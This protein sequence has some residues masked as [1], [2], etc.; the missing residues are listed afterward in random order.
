MTRIGITISSP[1]HLG[2]YKD[3]FDRI[4]E[5]GGEPIAIDPS[6]RPEEA[7]TQIDGLLLSGGADVTPA[8]YGEEPHPTVQAR[9]DLDA[10]EIPLARQALAQRLPVLGI[11]RGHQL[12]NVAC[13]GRL[14]QHIGSGEHEA[15]AETPEHPS[16]W[17][18]VHIDPDSRLGQIVGGGRRDV[19]SRHHQGIAP[20]MVA[21]GLIATAWSP[22]GLVEGLELAE[23]GAFVLSV[24]WHPER[25]EGQTG[26][27]RRFAPL[28]RAFLLAAQQRR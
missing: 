17:H 10:L 28:F 18:P 12:L 26:F 8:Y 2:W 5:L 4:R 22:D 23:P 25:P 9:P 14:V 15:H 1:K 27:H 11:C 20:D 6:A 21:P 16:R 3:Y 7:S 24:Q 13:G 19:N